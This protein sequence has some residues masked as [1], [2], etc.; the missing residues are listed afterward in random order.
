[1]I[2]LVG[3]SASGKTEVAKMLGKLFQMRKVI[4]HTTRPMRENEK[5][6]VDYYFVTREE[7]LNLKK[8]NFFVETTEYNDNFYGTSRKELEDNK[9]LIVD[10]NGLQSFLKLKDERVISFFMNATKETRRLRMIKRGDKIEDAIKRIATDDQKFN[11]SAMN[12]CDYVI[13]SEKQ[14]VKSCALEVYEKYASRL[15]LM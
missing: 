12:T 2:I 15:S 4:T 5:D 14:S 6:G 11:D 8:M 1:M 7:F 9:V 3:A 13:D 10:P